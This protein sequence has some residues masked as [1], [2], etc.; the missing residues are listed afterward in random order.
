MVYF[1]DLATDK[2][3]LCVMKKLIEYTQTKELQTR[4]VNKIL[5]KV[6]MYVQNEFG[7][8]VV[9]EVLQFFPFDVC[10]DIYKK[11]EGNFVKLSQNKYS[12]KFIENSI[13]QAPID[14][15]TKIVREFIESDHLYKVVESNFGNY[16]LQNTLDKYSK[17]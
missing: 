17:C 12:S 16:V 15:Q 9:S 7:N 14:L 8:F 13:N 3:G 11:I 4:I 2:Q 6:L 1:E 5:G 10:E